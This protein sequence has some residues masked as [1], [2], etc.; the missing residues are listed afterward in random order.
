VDRA[1]KT[2]DAWTCMVDALD[3][4]AKKFC[5][6]GSSQRDRDTAASLRGLWSLAKTLRGDHDLPGTDHA[7]V[8]S[9]R[10]ALGLVDLE[11]IA[12]EL[13]ARAL[14]AN[15]RGDETAWA[16]L[17]ANAEAV[18]ATHVAIVRAAK[19]DAATL[20]LARLGFT[21]VIRRDVTD[22]HGTTKL[23]WTGFAEGW[24]PAPRE[25]LPF[26]AS[27]AGEARHALQALCKAMGLP[28]T[29]IVCRRVP[30]L[31]K[32]P[33]TREILRARLL[34]RRKTREAMPA[35]PKP[36]V[37]TFLAGVLWKQIGPRGDAFRFV[38]RVHERD[39]R[40]WVDFSDG[41][42]EWMS[43]MLASSTWIYLGTGP[44]PERDLDPPTKGET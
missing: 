27:K 8:V 9:A 11:D 30:K 32:A 1:K 18:Q 39:M 2:A 38:T 20:H 17:H 3:E 24:L 15:E 7:A 28:G 16:M 37:A 25:A 43:E 21:H 40:G 5:A 36:N 41:G 33:P 19:I 23:Y 44:D 12:S 35:R 26:T 13:L 6:P 10:G 14:D 22:E 29:V 4:L 42:Q 31:K 34:R